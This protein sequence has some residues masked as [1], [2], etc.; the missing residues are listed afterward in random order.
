MAIAKH[1]FYLARERLAGSENLSSCNLLT[2]VS[3]PTFFCAALAGC[4]LGNNAR[5]ER[6]KSFAD[7]RECKKMIA[8]R[9]SVSKS[10]RAFSLVE[11]AVVVLIIG[12]LTAVAVPKMFNT[13]T[14]AKESAAKASLSVVRN[15]IEMYQ[16]EKGKYPGSAA[17]LPAD[18]ANYIKGQ[19]PK[20]PY[21][22]TST[23]VDGTAQD[24][25]EPVAAWVYD[26]NTGNFYVN[27]GNFANW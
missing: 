25:S 12:I 6:R 20:S 10:R 27:T 16:A 21:T 24:T 8:L 11:L 18:L 15:A 2:T 7:Y 1:Y 4:R 17:A 9:S 13:S 5:T 3:Q 26:K 14:K 23:I 22:G 19:F